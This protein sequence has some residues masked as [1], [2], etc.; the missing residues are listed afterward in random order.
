MSKKSLTEILHTLNIETTYKKR[1]EL[2]KALIQAY[3]SRKGKNPPK[4][5]REEFTGKTVKEFKVAVYDKYE[6]VELLKT[7]LR[8]LSN[9]PTPYFP[10]I[11]PDVY[12]RLKSDRAALFN[13]YIHRAKRKLTKRP[14]VKL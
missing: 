9:D 3:R 14:R 7:L 10:L 1:Q 12:E 2:G 8:N 5:W 13:H 4:E 11:A 6:Q